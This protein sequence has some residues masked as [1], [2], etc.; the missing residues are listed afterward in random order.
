[1]SFA[2]YLETGLRHILDLAGYDHILFVVA[3]CAVYRPQQWRPLLVLITAFT[4][5]HSLTLALA[6]LKLIVLPTEVIEFLIPV[7]IFLTAVYNFR[8][9]AAPT[10][11]V[12]RWLSYALAL[13]FG[14]I[15]GVGF[16]NY[17]RSLLGREADITLPLFAF[18]LGLEL[19]QVV[20][21]SLT[22]LVGWLLVQKAG[23]AQRY[24]TYGLSGFVAAVALYLMRETAFW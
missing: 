23:L 6:A 21:V 2:F 20:I 16:S 13:G 15:H 17:F 7:T 1:M 12:H 5:G 4:L 3:L 11:T 9:G 18:N 8:R 24:W 10:A 19:G 22:L 14:L